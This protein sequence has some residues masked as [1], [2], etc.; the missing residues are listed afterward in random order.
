MRA[1]K[2][3]SALLLLLRIGVDEVAIARAVVATNLVEE[4]EAV[5]IIRAEAT[6][7]AVAVML[8]MC[9]GMTRASL[10]PL[11]IIPLLLPTTFNTT[12]MVA[13]STTMAVLTP[14][15]T[16]AWCQI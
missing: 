10:M 2:Q 1:T 3:T 5:V 16:L 7:E 8:V 6:T 12:I 13:I 9:S 11:P 4:E 14:I 15:T